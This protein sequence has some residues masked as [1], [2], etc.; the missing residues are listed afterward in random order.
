MIN[1]DV[2]DLFNRV[3][4]KTPIVVTSLPE[5]LMHSA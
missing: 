1:Q 4:N 5:P 3:Q 2:V